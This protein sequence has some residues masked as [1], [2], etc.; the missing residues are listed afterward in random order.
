MGDKKRII[1]GWT[2]RISYR[3]VRQ[4]NA[5]KQNGKN[6]RGNYFFQAFDLSQGDRIKAGIGSLLIL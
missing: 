1:G 5:S 2:V 6:S 3:E 4:P